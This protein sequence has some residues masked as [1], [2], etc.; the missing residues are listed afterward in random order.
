MT[1]NQETKKDHKP[2]CHKPAR[3]T[4]SPSWPDTGSD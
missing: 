3:N 1:K 2:G 4:V